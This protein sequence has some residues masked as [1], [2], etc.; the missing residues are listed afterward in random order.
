[1]PTLCKASSWKNFEKKF[2]VE[3][4]C[5]IYDGHRLLSVKRL[6]DFGLPSYVQKVR[7]V[8]AWNYWPNDPIYIWTENDEYWKLDKVSNILKFQVI[9]SL[10]S[11]SK[12]MVG[13]FVINILFLHSSGT[14]WCHFLGNG[15]SR[16]GLSKTNK[17]SMA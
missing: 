15:K 11:N 3:N 1:M 4:K 12:I 2:F 8:Y 7:L 5:Y 10:L 9:F 6:T 17:C 16:T 13:S 14:I